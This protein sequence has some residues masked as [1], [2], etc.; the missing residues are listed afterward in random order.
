M[1]IENKGDIPEGEVASTG[2]MISWTFGDIPGY[3]L[4]TAYAE[5]Q[6]FLKGL[7]RNKNNIGQEN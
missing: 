1:C 7:E 2:K 6:I 3:Y 5:L 4:E